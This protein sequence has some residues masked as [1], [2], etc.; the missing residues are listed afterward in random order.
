M[1]FRSIGTPGCCCGGDDTP[2]T[3]RVTTPVICVGGVA[4]SWVIKDKATGTTVAIG[5]ANSTVNLPASGDYE[6]TATYSNSGFLACHRYVFASPQVVDFSV[7][8]PTTI[9]V[10][11]S[12]TIESFSRTFL[13]QPS[14]PPDKPCPDVDFC[15]MFFGFLTIDSTSYANALNAGKAGFITPASITIDGLVPSTPMTVNLHIDLNYVSIAG[16]PPCPI[17]GTLCRRYTGSVTLD[18][19]PCNP[20]S[21]TYPL[22]IPLPMS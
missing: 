6:L 15:S 19:D 2:C 16:N 11:L 5:N 3:A 10:P 9:A 22:I 17:A 21:C 20:N 13:F 1:P 12:T 8:C 7:A 18:I 4:T 14:F